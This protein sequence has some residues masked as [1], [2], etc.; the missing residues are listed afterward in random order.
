MRYEYAMRYGEPVDIISGWYAAE[1]GFQQ[2][3]ILLIRHNCESKDIGRIQKNTHRRHG[4][5]WRCSNC[6]TI[7]PKQ[8]VVFMKLHEISRRV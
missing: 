8:V 7:A 6:K 1:V 2:R 5:R 4:I 3:P